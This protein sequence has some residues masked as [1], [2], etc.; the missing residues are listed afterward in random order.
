MSHIK[1]LADFYPLKFVTISLTTPPERDTGSCQPGDA[2]IFE[3]TG[4]VYTLL[5]ELMRDT[6][7]VTWRA[8]ISAHWDE[9]K[10]GTEEWVGLNLTKP[11]LDDAIIV[12]G[13]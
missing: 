7:H 10:L 3:D 13:S 2:I 9:S 11:L 6:T 8:L 4:V 1:T 5:E 12:R